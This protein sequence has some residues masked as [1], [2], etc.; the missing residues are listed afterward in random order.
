MNRQR[1]PLESVKLKNKNVLT[2]DLNNSILIT[3]LT[4][5]PI[6]IYMFGPFA[7]FRASTIFDRYPVLVNI[8]VSDRMLRLNVP[9]AF[10]HE[11][12]QPN[13]AFSKRSAKRI[14]HLLLNCNPYP[15]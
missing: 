9:Y 14:F 10:V 6:Q 5:D 3:F 8:D 1:K 12:S 4:A 7:M 2:Y 11:R 13:V 15:I